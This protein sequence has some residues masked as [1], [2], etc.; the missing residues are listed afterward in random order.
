MTKR[1]PSSDSTRP[2]HRGSVFGPGRRMPI[3]RNGRARWRYIVHRHVRAGRIG[4]KGAW[5]L[6][7]LPDYLARDGRCDPSHA[8]LAAEAG[9]SESTVE[10]ALD[11]ARGLG[12]LDWDRRIVRNGWRTEQTSNA[13]VLL[14]P[15]D[16]GPPPAP[17]APFKSLKLESCF[18]VAVTVAAL[19]VLDAVAQ[20]A[21]VAAKIAE[22]K[23]LRR[24]RYGATRM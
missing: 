17:P 18:T 8:R 13:Y 5:A 11:D 16:G 1:R 14:V 3:D 9:I 21:R 4:P 12:L 7:V 24:A 22:E 20:A 19:P 10:R 6:E 23:A 2:W 15:C